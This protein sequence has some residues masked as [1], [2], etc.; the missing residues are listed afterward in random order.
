[1]ARHHRF[2]CAAIVMVL[3]A[4]I[5][6]WA[7]DDPQHS[8][9]GNVTVGAVAVR[10][11]R[12]RPV[13][14]RDGT[15][16]QPAVSP[17]REVPRPFVPNV[18]SRPGQNP[19]LGSTATARYGQ[20]VINGYGHRRYYEFVPRVSAGYGLVVGYP[21]AYPYPYIYPFLN[22]PGSIG[23]PPLPPSY[24]MSA[25]PPN[26]YATS[27]YSNVVGPIAVGTPNPVG[28][29]CG[30]DPA[31][32]VP[33]GGVSFDIAP[34]GAQ[35]S[36]EGVYVGTVDAFSPSRPP[37]ALSPGVHYIEIRMPGFRTEVFDVT[38]AA[39]EVTPYQG[40]LLPLRTQ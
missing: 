21:V 2:T 14:V 10:E 15:R 35:V 31:A 20:P 27:T 12:V 18:I 4:A 29:D 36:V 38:I 3:C 30:V 40:T 8:T 37:L 22:E 16:P 33:C 7:G 17:R 23:P 39:G 5:P 6:A 9:G 19:Y 25:L 34:A 11:V 24:S 13:I 1:M 26:A 32:S 28:L